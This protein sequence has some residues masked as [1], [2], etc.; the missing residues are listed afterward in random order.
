MMKRFLYALAL[1]AGVASP[2]LGQDGA[3]NSGA[4]IRDQNPQPVKSMCRS[5]SVYVICPTTGGGGSSTSASDGVN[6]SAPPSGVS[7]IAGTDGTSV[8]RTIATTT[9][10]QVQTG[11]Y[12][13][14]TTQVG[15]TNTSTDGLPTSSTSSALRVGNYNL[16][17]NGTLWD[18]MRSV[19]GVA[20]TTGTGLLAVGPMGLASGAPPT[21][22]AVGQRVNAWFDTF[23]RQQVALS[24]SSGTSVA[25]RAPADGA[26]GE[27][28]LTVISRNTLWNG[29]GFDRQRTAPGA[30]ATTGV[31]LLG[32]GM[33]G[34]YLATLPTF[35]TGQYGNVMITA[36]GV[37]LSAVADASGT[38]AAVRSVADAAGQ[39]AGL[40]VNGQLYAFNGA[41]YDRIRAAPAA[42]ATTGS[43]LL[44]AGI[45]G[46]YQATLPTYTTGQ[47]GTLAMN[48]RGVLLSQMT[49]DQGVPIATGN[50]GA[51]LIGN[52]GNTATA[53]VGTAQDNLAIGTAATQALAV[54]GF[55]LQYDPVAN[56][57]NRARGDTV[58]GLYTQ[59]K[60]R[61]QF[62]AEA[63]GVLTAAQQVNGVTRDGGAS[64]S[65]WG[66]FSCFGRSDQAGTLFVQGST[67]GTTWVSKVSVAM[68]ANASVRVSDR[69]DTRYS[70]CTVV[71]G[72]TATTL[73]PV[74]NSSFGA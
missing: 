13:N 20:G 10:G 51:I 1:I 57:Y 45:L 53:S 19:D 39:V 29:T 3:Y 67:D 69:N 11:L 17:F 38:T 28:G 37:V 26:G 36:K 18:R 25:I 59:E 72:A 34:Q 74:I 31:G 16:L 63:L 46:Q 64:P 55:E 41:S 50:N 71:N 7:V 8:V 58:G 30:N 44:G 15:G 54:R 47:F 5:G 12:T 40:T 4:P 6:G 42:D 73:A 32:A 35:T 23:G 48:A 70:R 27:A 21:A 68:P 56:V 33:L 65:Q 61:S 22:V 52:T 14:T 9:V 62:F 66:S 24:D 2:A 49:G 60:E 43:G